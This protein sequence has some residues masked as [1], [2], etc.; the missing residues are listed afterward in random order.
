MNL[1]LSRGLHKY[2]FVKIFDLQ[3]DSGTSISVQV[4]ITEQL[5][6][7]VDQVAVL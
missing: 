6:W 2:L 7:D 5:S 1:T 3:T 4:H